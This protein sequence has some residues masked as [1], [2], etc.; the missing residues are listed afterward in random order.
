[1]AGRRRNVDANRRVH[2][3]KRRLSPRSLRRNGRRSFKKDCQK[4]WMEGNVA[5]MILEWIRTDPSRTP[6]RDE[7]QREWPGAGTER[8]SGVLATL[9]RCL[10]PSDRYVIDDGSFFLLYFSFNLGVFRVPFGLRLVFVFALG[11]HGS[12]FDLSLLFF[13]F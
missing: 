10:G 11:C 4:W 8:P 1:M 12:F 6:D 9:W 3:S 5:Q 2:L 7:Y 13:F